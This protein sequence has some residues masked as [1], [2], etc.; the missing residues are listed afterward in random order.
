MFEYLLDLKELFSRT[1]ASLNLNCY[2]SDRIEDITTEVMSDD[3]AFQ[4]FLE[5][6][7][8]PFWTIYNIPSIKKLKLEIHAS[9]EDN[10]C[11]W[12]EK[13]FRESVAHALLLI[14]TFD[15]CIEKFIKNGYYGSGENTNDLRYDGD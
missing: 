13:K 14:L 5:K 2:I 1:G 3:R 10:D 12:A 9:V 4:D 7:D 11:K 15:E 8:Y 6:Y